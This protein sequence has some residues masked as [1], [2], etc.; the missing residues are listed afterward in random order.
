MDE[1]HGSAEAQKVQRRGGAN[2]QQVGR[3]GAYDMIGRESPFCQALSLAAPFGV[4]TPIRTTSPRRWFPL[5]C[6]C[7]GYIVCVCDLL[8]P[9]GLPCGLHAGLEPLWKQFIMTQCIHS[10]VV[11]KAARPTSIDSS[12]AR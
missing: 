6:Q 12:P 2:A 11:E 1:R 7:R 5:V 4:W 8:G 10:G 3:T 9:S